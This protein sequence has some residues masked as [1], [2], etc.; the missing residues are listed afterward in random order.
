MGRADDREAEALLRR[1]SALDA[2]GRYQLE[3]AMQSAHVDRAESG[4]PTGTAVVRLYDALFAISKSPVVAINRALA[5]AECTARRRRSQ[6]SRR[7]RRCAPAEYQPY[8]AARAELLAR[9]GADG[10]S[11]RAPT[12]S[13]SVSRATQR[14]ADSCSASASSWYR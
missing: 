2:I 11:A 5:I 6:R 4:A 12:K 14:C 3:A 8:W 13:R 10:R 1:A 7:C 9:T